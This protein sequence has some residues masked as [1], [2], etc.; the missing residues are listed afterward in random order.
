MCDSPEAFE[1]HAQPSLQGRFPIPKLDDSDSFDSPFY[2]KL[3]SL[4]NSIDPYKY[5]WEVQCH[6]SGTCI[7]E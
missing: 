1:R 3:V 6:L 7:T 5:L 2:P 4:R